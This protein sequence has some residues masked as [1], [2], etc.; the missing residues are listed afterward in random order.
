MQLIVSDA[1]SLIHPKKP[2]PAVYADRPFALIAAKFAVTASNS[3][4]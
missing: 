4:V 2:K 3:F 1:M